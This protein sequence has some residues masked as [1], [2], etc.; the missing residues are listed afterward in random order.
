MTRKTAIAGGLA[1]LLGA[2]GPTE[3]GETV[4]TESSGFTITDE[5]GEVTPIGDYLHD[6]WV[7]E[8]FRSE[9]NDIGVSS[10][11]S[12]NPEFETDY[13]AGA[14]YI[15]GDTIVIPSNP[16]L[17]EYVSGKR[18]IFPGREITA[19]EFPTFFG[20]DDYCFDGETKEG[21][22]VN[23]LIREGRIILASYI[24]DSGENDYTFLVPSNEP[25]NGAEVYIN[26]SND[27]TRD[28]W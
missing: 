12:E 21:D 27:P 18:Q 11:E 14:A 8:S 16:D 13:L 22:F 3:G 23:D 10:Y 9:G 25:W 17:G 15:E 26:S 28:C 4:V 6:P 7:W 1:A 20:E 2:C 24:T 5:S 19:T